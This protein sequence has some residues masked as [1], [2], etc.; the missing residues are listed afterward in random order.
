M[1]AAIALR[2]AGAPAEA[3]ARHALE[4]P[5]RDDP[6]IVGTL[7]EAA[8]ERLRSGDV[9][10]AA[11]L[12]VRALD[13]RPSPDLEPEIVADLGQAEAQLGEPQAPERLDQAIRVVADPRRRAELA[14]TKGQLLLA[15]NR[16]DE[17]VGILI[18]GLRQLGGAD[19]Q[20]A[21]RL[22][23]A[24]IAA[25][26]LVPELRADAL[27]R[28]GQM[29]RDLDG[30]PT[31]NQ[32]AALAHTVIIDALRGEPRRRVRDLVDL[33]WG[34]GTLLDAAETTDGP[35]ASLTGALLFVDELERGLELGDQ[36]L[37]AP[38]RPPAPARRATVSHLRAWPRYEQ[39]DIAG[40]EADAEEALD[41]PEQGLWT[42]R[43]AYGA[44][45]CCRA[46]RGQFEKAETAL[47]LI[48]D[49]H[50]STTLSHPL[51]LEVR[52]R[53]RLGQRR[54]SEALDDATR[55]GEMLESNFGVNNPGA[56]AW[57]STAA[58]A[59]IAL[60]RP[61][62]AQELAGAELASAERIGV[63]RI[64]IRDLRVLGL[65]VGGRDGIAL[66][67]KAVDVAEH[68]PPRLEGILAR[69]DLGAALRR[70]RRREAARGPLRK[71]LELSHRGGAPEV[72]K[73]ARM[74]L[75]A[76]GAR[77]RRMALSG[78]DSLTPGERRVADLA[79][80]QM[81]T[82]MIADTLFIAP[83][84]VEYHLR[85]IYQKLGVRSRS[86]L[87]AALSDDSA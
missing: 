38:K 13:E 41:A 85:H 71:A 15:R 25:A 81:T 43:S 3:I 56:V 53:L 29:L 67:E 66:L 28:R 39:G 64:I 42:G 45:A 14:L 10:R 16:P 69:V 60:G 49:E 83:K 50:L 37:A 5:P 55:A 12:L 27:T 86:E 26:S 18:E 78:P 77:P 82:R 36:I 2:E 21:S 30:P 44:L 31:P 76:A 48:D 22:E 63:T 72:A 59:E 24:H 34:E 33:A 79:R 46:L 1:R 84:T 9:H 32:R 80:Q 75:V 8:H 52:A 51:L 19:R 87:A 58:L 20:L 54:P 73:R 6:A 35:L 70:A 11:R 68:A 47:A 61:E 4:A 23:A 7:R 74:E 65:A 62:R 57:R 17:A 40:V